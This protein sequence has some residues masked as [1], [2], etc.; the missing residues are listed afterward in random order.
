LFILDNVEHEN[1]VKEFIECLAD[2]KNVKCIITTRCDDLKIK[3]VGDYD[4]I[5]TDSHCFNKNLLQQEFDS[6]ESSQK[7]FLKIISCLEN[8]FSTEENNEN[9]NKLRNK[10][11]IVKI[12]DNLYSINQDKK[13]DE[14]VSNYQYDGSFKEIMNHFNVNMSQ[15]KLSNLLFWMKIENMQTALDIFEKYSD[16]LKKIQFEFAKEK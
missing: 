2:M 1:D 12:D 13:F 7:N 14:I 6:L 9:L 15:E 11:F 8:F 4:E 3:N 5:S 10:S 16:A